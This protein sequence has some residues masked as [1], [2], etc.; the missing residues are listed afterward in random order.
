LQQENAVGRPGRETPAA[1][2]AGVGNGL[3]VPRCVKMNNT[4]RNAFYRV[5][6]HFEEESRLL[7]YL[8]IS[9]LVIV[10]DQWSKWMI[11][12]NMTLYESI[13]VIGEF[14]QIYSHRNK[15][16]AFGILQNQ[17]AFFLAVT[18]IVVAG[19]VWFLRKSAKEKQGLLSVA[20]GLLIGGAVGNFIDRLLTGEVVDFF[21]F[22][23][24]FP[25]FGAQVDYVFPIFNV[26]DIAITVSVAL[27]ILDSLI[28]WSQ[29]KKERVGHDAGTT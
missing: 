18:V 6:Q 5:C 21:K 16:A 4:I 22:H 12:T 28:K 10:L 15:G 13:P 9:L 11:K 1:G 19:A 20:L 17:R 8:L 29:E 23:F 3:P 14:F 2:N 24:R 7:R 26:A 25:F 27:I